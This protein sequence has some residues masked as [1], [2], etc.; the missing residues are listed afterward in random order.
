MTSVDQ[1]NN[2]N[3]GNNNNDDKN[4][5]HNDGSKHNYDIHNGKDDTV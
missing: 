1:K 5:M 2:G 4:Y 3:N